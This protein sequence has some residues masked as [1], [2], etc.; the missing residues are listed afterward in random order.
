MFNPRRLFDDVGNIGKLG[1]KE[2]KKKLSHTDRVY[3]QSILTNQG[4]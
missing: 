1:G 2:K 3:R 4:K